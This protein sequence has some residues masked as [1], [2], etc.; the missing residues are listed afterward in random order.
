MKLKFIPMLVLTSVLAIALTA[1]PLSVQ[2]QTTTQP[3]QSVPSQPGEQSQPA[4]SLNL[5]QAQKEKLIQIKHDASDQF[6]K[7]L[8]PEQ[9]E[10][11]KAAIQTPEGRQNLW[12]TLNLSSEQQTRLRSIIQT[13]KSRTD[14]VLTVEQRQ[15]AQQNLQQRRQQQNQ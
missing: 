15:Q 14:A 8:T 1:A 13:A 12:A 4:N 5:T 10:K 11:F 6:Q 3:S 7:L 2:A 9:Q